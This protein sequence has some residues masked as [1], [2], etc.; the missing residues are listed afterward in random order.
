MAVIK[1]SEFERL[2]VQAVAHKLEAHTIRLHDIDFTLACLDDSERNQVL[3]G[4]LKLFLLDTKKRLAETNSETKDFWKHVK[5][6]CAGIAQGQPRWNQ[7][8]P[9]LSEMS[10]YKDRRGMYTAMHIGLYHILQQ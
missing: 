9:S 3:H 7:Y 4:V 5:N 6:R 1:V 8:P 2:L 10:P